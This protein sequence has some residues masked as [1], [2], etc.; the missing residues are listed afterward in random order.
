M[1]IFP[2]S[3][4]PH[5]RYN[6]LLDEWILVSPHRAQRPWKG[7]LEIVKDEELQMYDTDCYLCPGNKRTNGEK[8]PQYKHTFVFT[9]DF[10]AIMPNVPTTQQTISDIIKVEGVEGTCRVMCFSP[11]HNMTLSQM[12]TPAIRTVVD[13]WIDQMQELGKTYKWVQVFENK[14]ALMGCSSPH[15]HCQIWASNF[16]PTEI[17]RENITQKSYY[18]KNES[19]LLVDYITYE[20][21]QNIRIVTENKHWIVIVPFWAV[22]PFETILLPKNHTLRMSSLDTQEKDSL[23][24]I[25]KSLLM[26]YDSLFNISFPYSMGWHQAP[27]DHQGYYHWQLHAHFYPPL[28]RSATVKKFMVGYEMLAEAQRDFTPEQAALKL[29]EYIK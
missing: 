1:T 22:W 12:N 3:D 16:I 11:R 14:G 27:K 2:P 7:S 8:N 28:I 25:M 19:P 18:Q 4:H 5:R 23:A 13:T 10:Q 15:P 24:S 6:P 21:E 9:N 20:Q 29:K 17:E 26:A